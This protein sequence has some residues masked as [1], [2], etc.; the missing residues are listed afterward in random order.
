M[1]GFTASI[2]ARG[3]AELGPAAAA[4]DLAGIGAPGHTPT[5]IPVGGVG[6]TGCIAVSRRRSRRPSA[7]IAVL[8]LRRAAAAG[9]GGCG[10]GDPS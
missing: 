1:G 3:I 7:G 4:R 9:L 2:A 5:D 10:A 6:R 8:S